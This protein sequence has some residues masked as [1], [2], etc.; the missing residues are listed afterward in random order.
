MTR[1]VPSPGAG[2]HPA[3]SN[4]RNSMALSAS[5]NATERQTDFMR[6]SAAGRTVTEQ[7]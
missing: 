2:I 6:I 3:G 7:A 1:P 4:A 5:D